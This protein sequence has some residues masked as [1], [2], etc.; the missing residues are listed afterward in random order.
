MKI[1]VVDDEHLINQ[2]I[3]SCI[4]NS[5]PGLHEIC[6][7]DSGKK[8]LEIMK[9]SSFDLAFIDI[10]MPK[11]DGLTLLRQIKS[12]Y[13]ATSVIMLTCH[14]DFEYAREAM[15]QN[16]DNYILKS[17]L[18][19][20]FAG[21]VVEDI[22]NKRQKQDTEQITTQLRK[23]D[24]IKRII[25]EGNDVL[26]INEEILRRNNIL[27]RNSAF[28]ALCFRN[29]SH[30]IDTI[31]S[32]TEESCENPIL[33]AYNEYILILFLNLRHTDKKWNSIDDMSRETQGS[34]LKLQEKLEGPLGISNVYFRMARLRESIREA[35]ES[36]NYHFYH[37]KDTNHKGYGER[38]RELQPLITRTIFSVQRNNFR[39][40][41][42]A[43]LQII[44]FAQNNLPD[45]ITFK[46]NI[47]KICQS[48]TPNKTISEICDR[49]YTSA[50]FNDLKS[51]M[52]EIISIFSKLEKKYSPAIQ[53]AIE[54]I[55]SN[56]ADDLTLGSI[57]DYVF[58]NR[59]HFSRQFKKE[60]GIGFTEFLTSFR[61][62]K[63]KEILETTNLPVTEVAILIGIP[64]LSYFS[65]IFRKEFNCSPSDI[66]QPKQP[67]SK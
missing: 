14:D 7:A 49:I 44:Q 55:T 61:L 9:Q 42:D 32:G 50:D 41:R 53:K 35:I 13:P 15:Q 3:V 45:E 34:L 66:R 23:N 62:Q 43:M 28:L 30:N 18:T 21:K 5:N 4:N 48:L 56:Y 25:S 60:V 8:A 65:T 6:S 67:D 20:E 12:K 63:A 1:I 36:I 40:A 17:E 51:A 39:D 27:F 31:I 29:T 38:I 19:P 22:R 10:T 54:Y 59:E 37:N 58:L 46:E 64:N 11:M 47:L 2:Y 16:A 26:V 57:S 52:E 33:Y 24:F